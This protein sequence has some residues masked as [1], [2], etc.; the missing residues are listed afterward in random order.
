MTDRKQLNKY[1][2]PEY[3]P[4][5]GSLNTQLGQHVLRK[6]ANKIAEGILVVRFE[7]P[8]NAWCT[9]CGIHIGK[10]VRYNAEKQQVTAI[11]PT[12]TAAAAAAAASSSSS[13]S[14]SAPVV[15]TSEMSRAGWRSLGGKLMY[16][17]TKVWQFSMT[18]TACKSR[19]VIRTD[20]AASNYVM[21]AGIRAQSDIN[22]A[23]DH[24][25]IRLLDADEK[26]RMA[27]DALFALEHGESDKQKAAEEAE[28]IRQLYQLQERR[29]DDF[30]ANQALRRAN[31]EVKKAQATALKDGAAKG[32]PFA[33]APTTPATGEACE[34][35]EAELLAFRKRRAV[36]EHAQQQARER[37][38]ARR[39]ANT[40]DTNAPT[41]AA[42]PAAAAA[43]MAAAFAAASSAGA[44]AASSSAAA[45][46]LLPTLT[47]SAMMPFAPMRPTRVSQSKHPSQ[48]T[49]AS[50]DGPPSTS[51]LLGLSAYGSDGE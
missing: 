30:G 39:A 51:S 45:A 27:S 14:A 37:K 32:L 1:Y 7:L 23:T 49:T 34:Q 29:I 22:Q 18:C 11:D 36:E 3:D 26:K 33:L 21:F 10:G 24:D 2:P 17:T 6:R 35:E 44:A 41:A 20:P 8:Y 13:S 31:R 42:A 48:E 28:R 9:S 38:K 16:H 12:N 4:T 46:P 40:V 25:T 43:L 5:K 47:P 50:S 19:I 15:I